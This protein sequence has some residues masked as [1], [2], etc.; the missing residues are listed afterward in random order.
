MLIPVFTLYTAELRDATP[1]LMGIA[2]GAYGL[3]QGL[4]QIPFGILSDR[5]GR[6]PIIALGLCC[7]GIGSLLGAWTDHIYGMI[8][9]RALQG[10]GAIGSVLMALAADLT[11]EKERPTAMA[12]IGASIGISFML[13]FVVSPLITEHFGLK[14]IFELS[15]IL[16]CLGFF[17]L[18]R[19]IPT[20]SRTQ[21]VER[22]SLFSRFKTLLKEPALLFLDI[23]IFCQH[24]LLTALFFYLPQQ[25]KP[26]FYTQQF[27]SAWYFYLPILLGSFF[28]VFPLIRYTSRK[29]NVR[30][31]MT[32]C[33]GILAITQLMLL[34]SSLML[35]G[36]GL[37]LYFTAF[38][39]LEAQLP[40]LIAQFAPSYYKGTAMGIYSSFQFLG[41]FVGGASAGFCFEKAGPIGIFIL[42]TSIAIFWLVSAIG[43]NR[44]ANFERKNSDL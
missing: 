20:P 37:F 43:M 30:Q 6:K 34:S 9:A 15:F 25:L 27:N 22:S 14:G 26:L 35:I 2:L 40:S 8:A 13:A 4:L 18:Y 29:Q 42:T 32:I 31:G 39:F 36:I 44:T 16:V 11:V 12:I 17:I 19:H 28:L 7:F 1:E 5:W 23:G 3:S 10:M 24:A 41:I 21:P 33:I 38:N